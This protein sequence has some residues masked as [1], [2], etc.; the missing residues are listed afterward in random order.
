MEREADIGL[1]DLQWA[2]KVI[3]PHLHVEYLAV[4][5]AAYLKKKIECKKV[6][7]L[8][9]NENHRRFS[10]LAST[11]MKRPVVMPKVTDDMYLKSP[12]LRNMYARG[13]NRIVP[14]RMHDRFLGVVS[15]VLPSRA[16]RLPGI[17]RVVEYH[18]RTVGTVVFNVNMLIDAEKRNQDLFRFNV[19]S[20]ALNPTVNEDEII[21][22]LMQGLG[23]I[24]HF[25]ACAFLV[26]GRGSSRLHV[27]SRIPIAKSTLSGIRKLVLEEFLTLTK[28]KLNEDRLDV[29]VSSPGG[30]VSSARQD[31]KAYLNAPLIT[32]DKIVGM[33]CLVH[34]ADSVF[35]PR[36]RQNV[37]MLA[38]SAAM[39]L[40]NAWL[41]DDLRR[42]YFSIVSALTSAIEAKDT[43]TRGHSVLVST[44]SV[45]IAEKMGLSRTMIES[46]EIA[47][48]LHDLG[49]IGV[50]EEILLKKD[51]LTDAEYE[52]L[53][54][55]PE[56]AL[57]ILGPV[58]FP[59][60]L[61]KNN[62]VPEVSPELTLKLFEL[63]D[64]SEEVKLMIYHHHERYSGGG[65][66]KG[67]KGEEIPLGARILSVADTFEALTA[68]RTYRKAFTVPEAV[69]IIKKVSGEQL[70]PNIVK[71]FLKV[72]KEKGMEGLS[73]TG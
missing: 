4:E 29:K 14:L 61:D 11:A 46:I 28:N 31:I 62:V 12:V 50:P 70:D 39:A 21:K 42:T 57:K 67:I 23:W 9:W 24:L 2:F 53:K 30:R 32:K 18:V 49:K 68:D 20:R 43:Y 25:D 22:I 10:A 34:C 37:T 41:Y 19:L 33:L 56:I 47:G 58:E 72:L 36:D 16:A 59:N 40:E 52:I 7:I 35:S 8:L 54:S 44:F 6:E 27:S 51:K 65:Y 55:H 66:P 48:L 5:L 64:L 1:L 13:V 69:R 3:G 45:A 17:D 38:G 60:F 71:V 63:A 15:V 73:R 26:L